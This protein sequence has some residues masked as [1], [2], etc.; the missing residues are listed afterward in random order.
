MPLSQAEYENLLIDLQCFDEQARKEAILAAAKTLDPRLVDY[1]KKI[2]ASDPSTECRYLARKALDFLAAKSTEAAAQARPARTGKTQRLAISAVDTANALASPDRDT[3]GSAL[4]AAVQNGDLRL[5][6]Y[7]LRR[8]KEETDPDIRSIIPGVLQVLAGPQS[9]QAIATLLEDQDPR[10]RSNAVESLEK[11]KDIRSYA[12]IV[13]SLQDTDLRVV[14]SGI[15]ALGASG[16]INILTICSKMMGQTEY[17]MRD[18]AVYCLAQ[19]KFFEAVPLLQKALSDEYEPVKE[20]ARKGLETLSA[21]GSPE[22]KQILDKLSAPAKPLTTTGAFRA[23]E[24]LALRK[25]EPAA[26]A[27]VAERRR[28]TGLLASIGAVDLAIQP[29]LAQLRT[30]TDEEVIANLL[31][32]IGK[33]GAQMAFRELVDYLEHRNPSIRSTAIDVLGELATPD[34]LQQITASLSDADPGVLCRAL[35]VLVRHRAIDAV[36]QIESMAKDKDPGRRQA[37]AYA[38]AELGARNHIPASKILTNDPDPAIAN[39]ARETLAASGG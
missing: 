18:A 30:E 36:A 3:R 21:L 14:T 22:A 24:I 11:I 27:P 39:L 10:V 28:A 1:L 29:I 6:P 16:K 23:L 4:R 38:I 2:S 33:S 34:A 31:R 9:L 5:L 25:E 7:I 20:K 13:K 35:I 8:V 37:A 19:S 17:W 26:P 15:R 12:L 32:S